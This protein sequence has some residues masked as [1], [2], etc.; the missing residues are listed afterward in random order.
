MSEQRFIERLWDAALGIFPWAMAI[1]VIAGITHFASIL[2]MPRLAPSDSYARIEALTPLHRTTLLPRV[3]ASDASDS[4][5][6]PA[7]ARG[8]CR[9]DLTRGPVRLRASLTPDSLM[10]LSFHSRYSDIYYSMTD[11]S[12]TRGRLEALIFTRDQ[13]DDVEAND[14]ED[15]L[16]QE[17]RIVA[18][19]S[20]GFVLMRALAE[21]PGDREDAEKSVTSIACGLDK[22]FKN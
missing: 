15:E 3:D 22:D 14:S 10:L 16:P 13:L 20:L 12:A 1:V 7:L 5:D 18:P 4:F 2:M 17:L 11:R 9:Y 19:T 21:R 8:A 6:D